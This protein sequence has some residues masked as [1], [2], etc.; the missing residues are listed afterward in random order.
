MGRRQFGK[1]SPSYKE[2]ISRLID[3]NEKLACSLQGHV[4]TDITKQL[5]AVVKRRRKWFSKVEDLVPAKSM[6]EMISLCLQAAEE[7]DRMREREHELVTRLQVRHARLMEVADW[8]RD[9][10][11]RPDSLLVD[12]D[13]NA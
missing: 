9:G 10:G 2:M 1:R 4:M 3:S 8:M 12:S 13:D 6:D 5:R 11:K 7:I